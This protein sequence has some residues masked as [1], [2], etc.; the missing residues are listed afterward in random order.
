MAENDND[1]VSSKDL[2]AA[3]H[4]NHDDGIKSIPIPRARH[5]MIFNHNAT[6]YLSFGDP[7]KP[8]FVVRSLPRGH[9]VLCRYDLSLFPPE[10]SNLQRYIRI[11]ASLPKLARRGPF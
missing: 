10:S 4:K 5:K 7:D 11:T 1:A 6:L 8:A 3:Y 2:F 9:M